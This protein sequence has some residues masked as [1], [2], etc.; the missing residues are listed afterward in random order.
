MTE[1][2]V[3]DGG[4]VVALEV[5]ADVAYVGVVRSLAA[6]LAARLPFTLDEIDDLRI[7]VDE[8]F[9]VLLP[10]AVRDSTV[11][12]GFRV[13]PDAIEVAVDVTAADGRTLDQGG[14]GWTLLE[15][16]AHVSDVRDADGAL[17]LTLQKDALEASGVA[18][19][20]VLADVSEPAAP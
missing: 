19:S 6:G 5:P 1:S 15:A 2:D 9:A 12:T 10:L 11:R 17:G 7:A 13:R 20:P 3:H 14:F 4:A 16:L 18:D 8:A